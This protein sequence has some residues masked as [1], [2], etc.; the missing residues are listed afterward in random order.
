MKKKARFDD[1]LDIEKKFVLV[2]EKELLRVRRR[3]RFVNFVEQCEAKCC[4]HS[5]RL[6]EIA[7]R[8]IRNPEFSVVDAVAL[9]EADSGT[10]KVSAHGSDSDSAR[11]KT[12]PG[13]I[14][15][16]FAPGTTDI[17]G[18]SL[19]WSHTSS[20]SSFPAPVSLS[21]LSGDM[22]TRLKELK[23]IKSCID[24][25]VEVH[26]PFDEESK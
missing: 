13:V 23:G 11:H 16:D 4:L 26:I 7:S 14:C 2:K 12:L 24:H 20:V 9:T 1:L 3:E 21:N 8:E 22:T 15:V 19:Y 25:F 18:V 5:S 17:C 10:V 6:H